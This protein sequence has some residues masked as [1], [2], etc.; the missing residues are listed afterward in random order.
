MSMLSTGCVLAAA[1]MPIVCAGIAKGGTF[2]KPPSEGGYD[3][4]APR[5]WLSRQA[6]WRQ[7]ANWAQSN[8]FEALP[9]FIGAVIIAHQLGAYQARFDILAFMV[10]FLPTSKLR[11]TSEPLGTGTRIAFEVSLPARLGKA[12]ATALPAP[13]SVITM[14]KA[15]ARPRRYFLCMLST[16]F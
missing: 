9:F 7:R 2:S 3:N 6:G 1:L 14:F 8:C 5:E 12:F 11:T 16:K 15:A 13:V 4:N 10:V